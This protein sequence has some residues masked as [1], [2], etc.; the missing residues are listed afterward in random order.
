[1][2]SDPS[3]RL[4]GQR[5][6]VTGA[7][8]GIG[9]SIASAFADAGAA[10]VVNYPSMRERGDAEA[11]VDKILAKE[12]RAIAIEADVSQEQAVEQMFRTAIEAMGSVD[13][14]V[15]NA[16]IQS[17]AP[18]VDMSLEQWNLVIGVNLTGQF[19][20]ARAA[21]REFLRRGV[22]PS[23]SRALGKIICISSVHDTI[24]WSRHANY[25]SSKAGVSMLMK[26]MAQELGGEGIRV[27][28]ISPGAIKTPMN[29]AAWSTP[30]AERELLELIPYKRVGVPEDIGACA[31]WLAS[32][33]A[34]YVHGATL[35]VDGGMLLYPGFATGG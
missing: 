30:E 3:K 22:V 35:Y 10:V 2:N 20:C 12:E 6:I 34:D 32:D 24:P 1:M 26:T 14:L 33:D 29:R 17:D 28:A 16:G 5:A 13:I 8:S 9:A 31:A 27:N 11:I 23:L 18:F 15:N 21:A 7:C 25:A 4:H 19:L